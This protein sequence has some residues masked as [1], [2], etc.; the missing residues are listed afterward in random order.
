MDLL[1]ICD[2][3]SSY[4]GHLENNWFADF[5]HKSE[6]NIKAKKKNHTL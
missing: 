5:W 3:V 6:Y 1:P 2:F 4:I